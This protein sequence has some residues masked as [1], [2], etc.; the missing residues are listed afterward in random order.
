M[1]T[2]EEALRRAKACWDEVDY[3][4]DQTDAYVFSK[5][6]DLSFGGN[7]PVAVLK[8]SGDCINYVA[9][10]DGEYDTTR[11]SEGYVA[12]YAP[13]PQVAFHN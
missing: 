7:S 1:I 8:S 4:T 12:D 2:Y 10:L 11:L 9:F 3:V 6:D 13:R 5:K